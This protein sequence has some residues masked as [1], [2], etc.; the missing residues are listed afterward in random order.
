MKVRFMFDLIS[1]SRVVGLAAVS[2][3]SLSPLAAVAAESDASRGPYVE[4]FGGLSTLG[5]QNFDFSPTTG[6]KANGRLEA[7]R[8]WLGGAALGYQLNE[9]IRVEAEM[10]YSR[11]Q[12]KGATA[13]GLAA[14]NGGDYASLAMMGSALLDV[15][16]Y[17]TDFAVFKPYVGVGLGFIEEVDADLKGGVRTEFDQGGKL[18]YQIR[19][20]VRWRYKSGAIAGIGLRYLKADSLLLKGPRGRVDAGYDPLSF[21]ASIGWSF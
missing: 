4:V 11:N 7:G 19:G 2:A 17:E 1:L 14:T 16:N 3:M 21:N 10:I 13:T 5:D 8:G 6:A 20:G 18:A 9:N 12:V 15:A